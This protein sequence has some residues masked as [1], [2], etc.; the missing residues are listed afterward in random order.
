MKKEAS[1]VSPFSPP[2]EGLH[3]MDEDLHLFAAADNEHA[4]TDNYAMGCM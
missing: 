2:P 1:P 3:A 4:D